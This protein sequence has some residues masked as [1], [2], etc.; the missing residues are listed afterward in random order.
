MH[1]TCNMQTGMHLVETH[2]DQFRMEQLLDEVELDSDNYQ[3][4][5]H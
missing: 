3:E 4:P 1:N 2:C 5:G